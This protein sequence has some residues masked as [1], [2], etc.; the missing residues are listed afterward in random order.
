MDGLKSRGIELGDAARYP[1]AVCVSDLESAFMI[2]A[3][4]QCEHHPMV[5]ARLPEWIQRIVFWDV[6][7]IE[8]VEPAVALANIERLVNALVKS[9]S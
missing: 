3:M 4:S 8:L 5:T 6:E 7:D 9:L 1:K 2:I